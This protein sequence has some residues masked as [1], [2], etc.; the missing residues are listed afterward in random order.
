MLEALIA[1]HEPP[2]IEQWRE[3]SPEFHAAMLGGIVAFGIDVERI[4]AKFKISQ[5]RPAEDR[6]R[7]RG[8]MDAGGDDAR[9]LAGW[10]ER[11]EARGRESG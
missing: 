3:Q 6:A 9:A 5:N 4:E 7:V 2:Y 10:M 1:R 8:A 11:F